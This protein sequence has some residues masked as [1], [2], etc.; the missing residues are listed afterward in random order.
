MPPFC[1]EMPVR[2]ADVDHAGI[3]YYPVFFHYFHLAFEELFRQRI[4]ARAY[5]ELLERDRIGFP[6]VSAQCEYRAPLK[7]GDSVRVEIA[8]ERFGKTSVT[9]DYKAL[10]V[11]HEADDVVAATGKVICAIVDLDEF[12]AVTV[13]ETLRAMF[14][15]LG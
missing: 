5:V 1:H 6:T 10:R 13:P 15:E 9:F 14:L 2:F 7:F 12:R 4:G 3:V 8:L 11:H